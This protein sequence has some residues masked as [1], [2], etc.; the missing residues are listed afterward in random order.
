MDITNDE[1]NII[2]KIL[3]N[4]SEYTELKI[5][6]EHINH[7]EEFYSEYKKLY[8]NCNLEGLCDM[9]LFIEIIK[10]ALIKNDY[11]DEIYVYRHKEIVWESKLVSKLLPVKM[12]RSIFIECHSEEVIKFLSVNKEY[13][14]KKLRC[15]SIYLLGDDI[16]EFLKENESL[17]SLDLAVHH[18][19]CSE[20]TKI[21]NVLEKTNVKELNICCHNF[22]K[23]TMRFLKMLENNYTLINFTINNEYTDEIKNFIGRN[24]IYMIT[25]LLCMNRRIIPRCVFKNLI[26]KHI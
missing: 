21:L 2:Q 13:K 5:T 26:F 17:E 4:K 10:N 25:I 12:F 15:S 3:N 9:K 18:D 1:F 19:F 6:K 20:L 23:E 24:K 22:T 8:D 14:V 11:I 7:F 16:S